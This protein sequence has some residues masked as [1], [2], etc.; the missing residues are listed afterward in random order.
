MTW[1]ISAIL[2]EIVGCWL[3]FKYLKREHWFSQGFRTYYSREIL[4]SAAAELALMKFR[5]GDGLLPFAHG[6]VIRW[7]RYSALDE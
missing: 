3:L 7:S 4:A 1:I 5:Q 6:T 2:L